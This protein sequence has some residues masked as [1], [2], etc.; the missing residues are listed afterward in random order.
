M[1]WSFLFQI[2]RPFFD[3]YAEEDGIPLKLLRRKL[4]EAGISEHLPP[5]KVDML[6][7]RA[8]EDQDGFLSYREF[9]DLVTM[10]EGGVAIRKSDLTRFQWTMR[11]FVSSVV[12]NHARRKDGTE[13]VEHYID[14]YNCKPPPLFMI[15][16]SVIEVIVFI[17][18]AVELNKLGTPVT[19]TTGC[20]LYS[21]LIYSPARRYEA[22][23]YTHLIFNLI[24]Q[25]LLGIPLEMVHKW[26][27]IGIVYTLGVL[28]G[29]LAHSVTDFNTL[30]AGAS[31]GC[32][33]ILG[34]HF[35]IIIMNLWTLEQM[36][37]A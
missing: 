32:Y 26:W 21:P 31:G 22:W 35:A 10:E 34:A 37:F 9:M 4:N 8:D 36:L 27:R 1:I 28:A 6:I 5:H 30:L 29:S 33:A 14:H 11:T 20:P 16:I 2:F 25:L 15:L 19:A 18:Y 12:P 17:I 7:R 3:E 13:V 24:F 23:S